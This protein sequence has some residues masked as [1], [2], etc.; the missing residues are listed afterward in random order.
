MCTRRADWC[1]AIFCR[2]NTAI[3]IGRVQGREGWGARPASEDDARAAADA[4]LLMAV[5]RGT[6][7]NVTVIVMLLQ[8]D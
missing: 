6:A 1:P 8:W 5:R 2:C 4:L 7:D 3:S